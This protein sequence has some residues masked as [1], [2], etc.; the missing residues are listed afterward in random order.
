MKKLS[1]ILITFLL[2]SCNLFS[3]SSS[4]T[5]EANNSDSVIPTQNN[6]VLRIERKEEY[7]MVDYEYAF[8]NSLASYQIIETKKDGSEEILNGS[9]FSW[10]IKD[11]D[12]ASVD[13]AGNVTP[14]KNGETTIIAKSGND[15]VSLDIKIATYAMTYELDNTVKEYRVG[16]TYDMPFNMTTNYQNNNPVTIWYTT[17]NDNIITIDKSLNKFIVKEAGEVDVHAEFYSSSRGEKGQLDFKI[18]ASIANAPYFRFKNFVALSGEASVAKNKYSTLPIDKIGVTAFTYNDV[19]I[20]NKIQIENNNYNLS[21]VGKY[22][23]RLS[24]TD[25]QYNAT[26]YFLLKLE[27]TE[28]ELKTTKSPYDAVSYYNYSVKKE[29]DSPYSLA[30]DRIIF[31]CDVSLNSKYDTSDAIVYCS[32]CFEIQNWGHYI[33]YDKLG[34]ADIL[35]DQFVFNGPHTIHFTYTFH[36]G[37]DLDP[38]TFIDYFP[39]VYIGGNVYN[40]IYY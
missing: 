14:K 4:K 5:T 19:D 11:K 13:S 10:Y 36:P 28:Y 2:T 20:S 39:N 21:E 16:N 32:F 33:T 1:L 40:L 9:Y 24:V 17:S 34:N 26:S 6:H 30:I 37:A 38:D 15:S 12:M 25:S 29:S 27:V 8:T 7:G 22:D 31:D 3:N 23:I 35:S 18:I